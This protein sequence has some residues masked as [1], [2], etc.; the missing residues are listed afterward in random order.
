MMGVQYLFMVQMHPFHVQT[1]Q[2]AQLKMI[3]L[4]VEQSKLAVI[5]LRFWIV[6]LNTVM[7]I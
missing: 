3:M 6:T 7:H 4:T 5:M 1:L 2:E